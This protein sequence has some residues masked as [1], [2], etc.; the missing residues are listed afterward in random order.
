MKIL[1]IILSI[2]ALVLI[3]YNMTQINFD[4]PFDGQSLIAL[5]TILASLCAIL[6][7]RILSVSKKIEKTLNS[8]K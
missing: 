6:L 4:N 7:L 3:G 8:K 1:T 2:V 5:I